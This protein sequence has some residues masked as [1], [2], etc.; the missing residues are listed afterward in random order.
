MERDC[1]IVTGGAR[2]IGRE[3]A[4]A[5]AEAGYAIVVNYAKSAEDAQRLVRDIESKGGQAL[6]V[7]AD[8][9]DFTQAASLIDQAIKAFGGIYILV[10]NAGITRDGLIMRMSE[11]DYSAVI[12]TNL[13][14]AFNCTRHASAHMV[15]AHR[16]RILN[17]ASV[18]GVMGNAGQ[19]NYAASKGGMIGLT[20]A[21]ARELAP[22]SITVNAIAPGLVE[23]EMTQQLSDAA[24][25]KLL[26]QVPLKRMGSS[27]EIAQL[28]LFLCSDA[29]AYITGQ[30]I[31]IDGGMTMH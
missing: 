19:S 30:T 11:A 18:A 1:A 9:S 21:V 27:K 20:K 15:R 29:A 17:I 25:E 16:G 23:T 7:Q 26:A 28:A 10:N 13:N 6:A 2:G 4:L 12:A 3:I 24:R 22:R 5:L 31:C 14:G 8:V